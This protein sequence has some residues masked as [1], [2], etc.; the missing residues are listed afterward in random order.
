MSLSF[1]ALAALLYPML[2]TLQARAFDL[3]Y[4]TTLI[5][6]TSGLS[7]WLLVKFAWYRIWR[8]QIVHTAQRRVHSAIVAAIALCSAA[9]I[10]AILT[11]VCDIDSGVAAILGSTIGPLLGMMGTVLIYR[12]TPLDRAT[13]A[14]AAKAVEVHCPNCDYNL[15]G[16][17]ATRCPECGKEYTLEALLAAQAAPASQDV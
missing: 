14:S 15:A 13:R 7:C 5:Y 12:E 10:W 6:W 17:T 3:Y 1:L 8:R 4:G 9:L 2:V 16:L 11:R